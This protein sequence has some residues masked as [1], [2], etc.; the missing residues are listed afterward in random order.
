MENSIRTFFEDEIKTTLA[1]ILSPT[2]GIIWQPLGIL[3]PF[4][5]WINFK[6]KFSLTNFYSK[7]LINISINLIIFAL[8]PS[9]LTIINP[10][11]LGI[12][13]VPVLIGITT[14]ILYITN[15]LK[16]KKFH[17]P[18]TIKFIKGL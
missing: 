17:M 1:L 16:G 14:Q 18:Y 15:I 6:D 10:L 4:L 9:F 3:I 5:I 7:E 13:I 8:V 12:L 11:Y 2:L